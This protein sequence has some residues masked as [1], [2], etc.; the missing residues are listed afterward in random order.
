MSTYIR[1]PVCGVFNCPSRLWRIIDGRR[2]CQYGH[3]MEGDVEFN[4]EDDEAANA[5]VVT[6]RLNLT[7]SATGNFQSSFSGSQSQSLQ[8][9]TSGKKIYGSEA[10]ILFLKAFQ[11]IVKQQSSWLIREMNFPS[12]FDQIVKLI[13]MRYLKW[14]DEDDVRRD[15]SQNNS[16]EEEE[17]R[18][19]GKRMESGRFKLN[20]LSAVSFMYMAAV[21]L[22]LP[23]YTIDFVKWIASAKFPYY[24]ATR[25]IPEAWR[26]MLPS[27]HLRLLEGEK[28]P[29][30][31]QIQAK[32]A[33]TCY[34][35]KFLQHFHATMMYEGLVLKLTMLATLPPEFYFFT[36]ELISRMDNKNNY[37]LIEHPVLKFRKF[38]LWPELRV[39]AF[40][41]LATR[42]LLMSDEASYPL[43]WVLSLSR[44]SHDGDKSRDATTDDLLTSI[45][46]SKEDVNV[47]EWSEGETSRYLKWFEEAFLP[48]Q[49]EDSKMK[50]DHRIA[51]RKLLKIFP[52][53]NGDATNQR[54]KAD[55][56]SF[57]EQLQEKY[58]YFLSDVESHWNDQVVQDEQQ[59]LNSIFEL[60][61]NLI[62]EIAVAF[63][64]SSDQIVTAV[65]QMSDICCHRSAT[66]R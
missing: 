45:S 17:S 66:D 20:I 58:L 48:I 13:W 31:G 61:K 26:E 25:A 49:P 8:R 55:Q 16:S 65:R 9:P 52:I 54:P 39:I 1:G 59:R 23:V 2:T 22:G 30:H 63:A 15:S 12:E 38:N 50:I 4:N 6:R 27:S 51:R 56:S 24:K 32:V 36:V 47:F 46:S 44:R 21:H 42:W 43:Q 18:A 64:L 10:N 57:V 3:V 5:G 34:R 7:T 33:Q 35:T 28:P 37:T 29:N 62:E 41:V 53:G 40:F 11:L 19:G 60:E 14:I